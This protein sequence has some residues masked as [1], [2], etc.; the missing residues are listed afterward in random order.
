LLNLVLN[1]ADATAEE[2]IIKIGGIEDD[3]LTKLFVENSG[4]AVSN[5]IT[6]KIFEP[7]FTAKPKG[8]GLGLSIV[9]N[10]ARSHSGDI[11][12]ENNENGSVRFAMILP[13]TLN[14]DN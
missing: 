10:I 4:E 9:R 5:E 6:A 3:G 2:G 14:G 11:L 7:F 12:L 8:T 13:K 1:A